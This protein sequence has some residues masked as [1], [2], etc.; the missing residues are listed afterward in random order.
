MANKHVLQ[1]LPNRNVMAV[2]GRVLSS[3]LARKLLEH[4]DFGHLGGCLGG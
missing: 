4:R 1:H 3:P 2:R